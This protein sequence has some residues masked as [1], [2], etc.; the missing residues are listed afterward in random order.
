MTSLKYLPFVSKWRVQIVVSEDGAGF[1]R[2]CISG[3]VSC[4]NTGSSRFVRSR[5]RMRI[6]EL[7]NQALD[8]GHLKMLFEFCLCVRSNQGFGYFVVKHMY[9]IV[10]II[11]NIV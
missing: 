8:P 4:G 6:P 7:A 9:K 2:L 5:T 11:V 3:F 10:L 1:L